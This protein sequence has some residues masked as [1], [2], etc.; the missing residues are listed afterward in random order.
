MTMQ[1]TSKPSPHQINAHY[2]TWFDQKMIEFIDRHRGQYEPRELFKVRNGLFVTVS[3]DQNVRHYPRRGLGHSD[4]DDGDR[5][6]TELDRFSDVYNRLCR[7]VVGR[8][9]HR[10]SHRESLPLVIACLDV[11][12]TR[13]WRSI[14]ELENPH[15]HS[16]W[17]GTNEIAPK[18]LETLKDPEWL[19]PLKARHQIR[20]IDTQRLRPET[21]RMTGYAA[22]LIGHNTAELRIADDFRILPG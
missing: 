11:N 1:E 10:P 9:F 16:I 12:G 2:G 13:H 18:V 14:G 7:T 3:F 20:Q 19:G 4:D 21:V 17:L 15:I 6:L 22:K 8:N 5:T